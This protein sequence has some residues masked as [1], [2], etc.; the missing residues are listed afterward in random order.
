MALPVLHGGIRCP[1]GNA[2]LTG[3]SR[4]FGTIPCYHVIHAVGPNYHEFD[5]NAHDN[6]D[7]LLRLA[8]HASLH[9]AHQMELQEVAFSLLSASTYR[10][11]QSLRKIL[12]IGVEGIYEWCSQQQ[13]SCSL[14]GIV[15][16]AFT[17]QEAKILME[18]CQDLGLKEL[19]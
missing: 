8:Y 1:T 10:G 18:E 5:D 4:D 17:E 3:P 9:C 6:A 12:R 2:K 15:M 16:C 11:R 7:A 13:T 19:A 14:Q